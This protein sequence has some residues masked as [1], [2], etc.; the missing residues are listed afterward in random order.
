MEKSDSPGGGGWGPGRK[1]DDAFW[2]PVTKVLE[3]RIEALERDVMLVQHRMT[4]A[5]LLLIGNIAGMI[6][7]IVA[8]VATRH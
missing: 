5:V 1:I 7:L 2:V 3:E 8:V 6:T 4:Q